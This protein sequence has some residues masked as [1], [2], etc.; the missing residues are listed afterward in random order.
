MGGVD[1]KAAG[2]EE[3]READL[4][5]IRAVLAGD[6]TAYR[7]LVEKYQGRVYAM[8]YG[9]LRDREDARDVAQ[10][11]FV[12]AYNKLRPRGKEHVVAAVPGVGRMLDK[13]IGAL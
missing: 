13:N 8:V 11:A 12:K 6:A 4:E 2:R 10:D 5:M 3:S 1:A 9:M 7:G